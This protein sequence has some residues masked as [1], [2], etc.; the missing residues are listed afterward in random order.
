MESS[1]QI[2]QPKTNPIIKSLKWCDLE[3]QW[4]QEAVEMIRS[5][6]M[7]VL[8]EHP[9]CFLGL[10]GGSTPR[11]VYEQLGSMML[12]WDRLYFFLIDERYCPPESEDSNQRLLK[13]TLLK[14]PHIH[15]SHVLVPRCGDLA[16]RECIADYDQRLRTTIADPKMVI[17]VMGMG[18]DGHT[19]SLFPHLNEPLCDAL[20]QAQRDQR[21]LE[22]D[23]L[24][25]Q[26]G[27]EVLEPHMVRC[28]WPNAQEVVGTSTEVFAVRDRLTVTRLIPRA[29][30]CLLLLRGESKRRLFEEIAHSSEG[31]GRWP[32]LWVLNHPRLVTLGAP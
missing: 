19:A 21:A 1:E 13:E 15:P 24:R 32:I 31:G 26:R 5:S 22:C 17:A 2:P 28:P 8:R 27:Q 23:A 9:R 25:I 7:S 29:H 16:Y 20:D 18:P 12:P 30:H 10:S 11:K 14:S 6:I 4:L 3:A